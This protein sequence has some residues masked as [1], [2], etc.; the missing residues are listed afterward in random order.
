[1]SDAYKEIKDLLLE[2]FEHHGNLIKKSNKIIH[3]QGF[4]TFY[5]VRTNF[6]DK[7]G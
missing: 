7:H 6:G 1:M 2:Y 4:D 5:R 3:K